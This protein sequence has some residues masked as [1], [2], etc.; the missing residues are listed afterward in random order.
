M[1]RSA[2]PPEDVESPFDE[3]SVDRLEEEIVGLAAEVYALTCRWLCLIA[4]FDRREAY[5]KSGFRGSSQW[6]A[7][8]CSLSERAA[9]DHVRTARRLPDLPQIREAFSRGELSYSK[10]RAL[11]RVA[12]SVDEGELLELARHAT[13]PQLERIVRAYRG[14][15]DLDE[16]KQAHRD[17]YVAWSWEEDGALSFRGRLPGEE[18]SLFMRAFET[19]L[20]GL[21][22]ESW[23]ES[24]E[25]AKAPQI[26]T[27]VAREVTN[28]D[29]ILLMGETML[30]AGPKSRSGGDRYQVVVHVDADVLSGE[31]ESGRCATQ[32][33]SPLAA[34]TARRLACDAS[35]VP[36]LER[37]GKALSLGRKRRTVSP[38]L[39]RALDFR[40]GGCRFPGCR[41][42]HVDNHHIESW[43]D[44]G[45]TSAE[46]LVQLCRPHHRLIHEGGFTVM[47]RG[48]KF[49]FR[50]PDGRLIADV[51]CFRRRPSPRHRRPGQPDPQALP[52]NGGDRLDLDHTMFVLMAAA[53]PSKR[54]R[55]PDAA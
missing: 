1:F 16:A 50:R 14:A 10:V 42:R 54:C 44:G 20:D 49:I 31:S 32:D 3:L 33:G 19:A 53:G 27:S 8:R 48:D 22:E 51:P 12:T 15:L 47:R 23:K 35:V 34:E 28:A 5:E 4:E 41:S 9:R 21:R 2:S 52:I 43:A 45:E 55:G 6:L 18:G 46:N 36:V 38:A 17:R 11:A 25:E 39:R 26:Q 24:R 7:W 37:D 40:D 30:A 13:T 29:A